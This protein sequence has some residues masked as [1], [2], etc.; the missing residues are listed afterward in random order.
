MKIIDIYEN[1]FDG[2]KCLLMVCEYLEGGD[3]LTIF[4]NNGSIPY[5][6]KRKI[7]KIT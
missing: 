5:T 3:L 6:E 2:L 4:E 1:T 7:L